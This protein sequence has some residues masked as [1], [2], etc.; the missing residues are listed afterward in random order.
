[1]N[2]C[3]EGGCLNAAFNRQAGAVIALCD[4]EAKRNVHTKQAPRRTGRVE[5]PY[6]VLLIAL[7][8]TAAGG[9]TSPPLLGI[10]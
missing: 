4:N 10:R 2:K 3:P 7:F 9:S 5:A 8:C 6:H 1:M